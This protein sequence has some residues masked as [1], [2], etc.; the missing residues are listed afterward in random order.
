MEE[1]RKNRFV[2]YDELK[3]YGVPYSRKH[4]LDLQRRHEFPTAV[5]LSAHRIAWPLAAIEEWLA[6]RP[7]A[8][9]ILK[10]GKVPTL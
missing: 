1:I 4:L 10:G 7:Y 8:T 6:N 2:T 3:D 9:S 5:Q